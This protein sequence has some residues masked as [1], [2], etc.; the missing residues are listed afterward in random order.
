MAE[1]ISV[2]SVLHIEQKD[3]IIVLIEDVY[4]MNRDILKQI[5]IDQKEIYLNN[6]LV[7]RLYPLE[8]NSHRLRSIAHES[9]FYLIKHQNVPSSFNQ[10]AIAPSRTLSLSLAKHFFSISFLSL[11]DTQSR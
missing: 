8:E 2:Q 4:I 3:I 10:H 5:M 6:P 1:Q 9:P 11:A 7:Y